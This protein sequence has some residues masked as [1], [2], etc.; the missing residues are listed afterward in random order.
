MCFTLNHLL[1]LPSSI[2]FFL[3]FFFKILITGS[4]FYNLPLY[5]WLCWI[6]VATWAFLSLQWVGLPSSCSLW[7]S[8]CSGFPFCR[9]QA[10]GPMRPVVVVLGSTAQ[11]QLLWCA[12]LVA[13]KHVGAS[14][15]RDRTHVFWYWQA[16]FFPLSHQGS[17]SLPF[18]IIQY[19]CFPRGFI[20]RSL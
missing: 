11:A 7:D 15:T 13:L 20:Q 17:P 10:L 14:R 5:F 6:L 9:A 8:H 19:F 12:G 18:L 2:L 4:W 1:S 3:S 16:D